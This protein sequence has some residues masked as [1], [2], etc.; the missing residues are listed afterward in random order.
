MPSFSFGQRFIVA[1]AS[2]GIGKSVALLL[3]ECGAS[4]I[5]IARNREALSLLKD[6]AKHPEYMFIEQKDF[7][8]DVGDIPAY[9]KE[10]KEKYGKFQGMAFCAGTGEV[11]PVRAVDLDD[12]RKVFE[13]NF[14]APYM[15]AKAFADKRIHNGW[16]TSC[17]FVSSV[18]SIRCDKGQSAYA[19]SKAALSASV[20]SIA[21]ECAPLGVRFNCVSPSAINT[22]LLHMTPPEILE[23]QAEMYPMGIGDVRDAANLI[24]YLLSNEAKWITTQNYI[25]DC[26]AIL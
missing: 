9:V 26:G 10:L 22:R 1:G 13:L 21:R 5:S 23:K 3:N 18:A 6:E 8:H 7:T 16:G 12:L 4:V 11:K 2:H 14:F 17:V 19:G 15:M 20:K 24:V 25:I